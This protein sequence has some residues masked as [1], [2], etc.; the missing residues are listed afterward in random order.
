MTGQ[1]LNQIFGPSSEKFTT[2]VGRPT[3]LFDESEPL[4]GGD[5]NDIVFPKLRNC[6]VPAN[7]P[8]AFS[9]SFPFAETDL[10]AGTQSSYGAP[11]MGG[12]I[13]APQESASYAFEKLKTK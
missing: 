2:G 12:G 1:G 10:P 3:I 7:W 8:N 9:Y 5:V 6:M 11:F 4:N 13:G